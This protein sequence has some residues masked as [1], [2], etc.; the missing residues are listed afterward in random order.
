MKNFKLFT[1]TFALLFLLL[2]ISGCST[3]QNTAS[4]RWWKGFKTRYNT[5]YNGHQAYLEGMD[6]KRKGIKDNYLYPLPLLMVGNENAKKLG[7][8]NF[9]TTVSKCEKAIQM[10]S[11]R[12]KPVFKRGHRLTEK[13]KKL[14]QQTE[15]N[16]F[17]QNAWI[18]MGMAQ[19][20]KG[21]FVDAAATFTYTA[22]LYK[23]QTDVLNLARS[24]Q[25]I[26][27]VESEWYY[28]AEDLLDKVRRDGIPQACRHYYNLALAD[29]HLHRKNW[30]EAIPHLQKE[31]K[32]MRHGIERARGYFLL[33]QVYK[34]LGK[35]KESYSALRKCI[36]QTPPY[37]MKFNAQ[38]L[39]TEVLAE[40]GNKHKISKLKSLARK[41]N[42]KDYLDQIYYAIGNV[43]LADADTTKAIQAYES[44]RW[45]ST[46]SN[47]AKN[48]LLVNLGDIYWRRE[49]FS[50][51]YNCYSECL[52]SLSHSYERYDTIKTRSKVL[53][54]LSPFTDEIHLQDSLQALTRM[55][56]EER[57]QAIDRVIE[58][59]KKRQEEAEKARKDSIAEARMKNAQQNSNRNQ[60]EQP[61]KKKDNQKASLSSTSNSN[62]GTWY[63]YEPETVQKGIEIFKK[64]WG[65]RTNTDNWR[66]SST[67]KISKE[68]AKEISDSIR[69]KEIQD[70]ELARKNKK[71]ENLSE[72]DPNNKLGRAYYMAQLPFTEKQIQESN[73]KIKH[74]LYMA[75][76]IEMDDLENYHLAHKTLTRLYQE[77]P[78]FKPFDGLLYKLFLLELH[79]GSKD[80]ANKYKEEMEKSY[81]SSKYT[82]LITDPD[83]EDKARYGKAKEDSIYAVTYNA[84]RNNDYETL[85]K[86]CMISKEKYPQGA[87]RSK[88][89]FL[90]SLNSLRKGDL[91]D[92]TIKLDSVS[93]YKD[94]P[95]SEIAT[96]FLKGIKSGRKPVGGS[97]TLSDFWESRKNLLSD[98][99]DST[100]NDSLNTNK[101]EPFTFILSYSPA[102]VNEG[103]L[104]YNVS[105][106]NFTTF[107]IRNFDLTIAK[108]DSVHQLIVEGF[109]SFDEIH[110]YAQELSQDSSFRQ[111]MQGTQAILISNSNL[112]LIGTKYTWEEYRNFYNKHFVPISTREKL[113]LDNIPDNFIWDEFEET[114][115]KQEEIEENQEDDSGEWY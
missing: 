60:A 74:A 84:F 78:D 65:K 47:H 34:T 98:G 28:D 44:G 58:I 5:Y 15:Y 81:P 7:S 43:Y 86:N 21:D 115:P 102:N 26:C 93:R 66:L 16:P 56:E 22:R 53:E 27:Y 49:R 92:F 6:A 109:E 10:Y 3:S 17:L 82:A 61:E 101:Q 59:E 113:N 69:N 79:W 50:Q 46:K 52:N 9:E 42:N 111:T 38:V 80:E 55:T 73:E 37:E 75:G 91:S 87:N 57:N 107:A 18:L 85:E 4:V 48:M 8:S 51:A 45:L 88:F 30:K 23:T 77:F 97:Y 19:L 54:K 25:A 103:K 94:D 20:Q 108:E 62:K 110:Q 24:L 99:T 83:F 63:F 64:Q 13:E 12:K 68:R 41:A 1:P 14:K 89:L 2:T 71:K 33:A 67:S 36:Q 39:Q 100:Q 32:N 112:K 76:V 40:G 29:L 106:F 96:N 11:I 35:K 31:V 95:I 114:K 70:K 90:E 105:K 72:D 104:L